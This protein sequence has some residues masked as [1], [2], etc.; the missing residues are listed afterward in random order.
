MMAMAVIAIPIFPAHR[1]LGVLVGLAVISFEMQWQLPRS[2]ALF[3]SNHD[4]VACS[5]TVH[6]RHVHTIARV[7]R[8]GGDGCPSRQ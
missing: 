1:L 4:G 8:N 6:P 3:S 5:V 7:P 2:S